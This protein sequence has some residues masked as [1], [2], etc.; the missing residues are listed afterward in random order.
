M[1]T[2]LGLHPSAAIEPATREQL[3]ERADEPDRRWY[4]PI[5]PHN[6]DVLAMAC[7]Q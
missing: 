1:K 6:L 5:V 2:T 3:K 4:R 7:R